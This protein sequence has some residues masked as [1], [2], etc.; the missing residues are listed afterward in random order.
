MNI[1]VQPKIYHVELTEMELKTI[2]ISLGMTSP[3]RRDERISGTGDIGSILYRQIDKEFTNA[4]TRP[5]Q[6]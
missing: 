6:V 2:W 1:K 5:N 3:E 4:F